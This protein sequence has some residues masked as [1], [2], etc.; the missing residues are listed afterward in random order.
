MYILSL[1]ERKGRREKNNER[2]EEDAIP[3]RLRE[4]NLVGLAHVSVPQILITDVSAIRKRKRFVVCLTNTLHTH[5][6]VTITRKWSPPLFLADIAHPLHISEQP[7]R[8]AQLSVS[9][10]PIAFSIIP[11]PVQAFPL[12]LLTTATTAQIQR[13]AQYQDLEALMHL[14]SASS[15]RWREVLPVFGKRL[16]QRWTL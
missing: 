2:D 16:P 6:A 5:S 1:N 3:R 7:V 11:M 10:I 8:S 4:A 13:S 14:L 9:W 15:S 12:R